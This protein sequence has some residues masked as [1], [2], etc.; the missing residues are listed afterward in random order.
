MAITNSKAQSKEPITAAV[1][2]RRDGAAENIHVQ[3]ALKYVSYTVQVYY[4]ARYDQL[5]DSGV[6]T[7]MSSCVHHCRP[8]SRRRGRTPTTRRCSVRCRTETYRSERCT[9][10]HLK[11]HT[12]CMSFI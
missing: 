8:C 9:F 2:T 7:Y 5:N 6:V 1:I 12:T 4:S 3:T 10:V 11:N